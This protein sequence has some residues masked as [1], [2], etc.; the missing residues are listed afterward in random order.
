MGTDRISF[1]AGMELN[2]PPAIQRTLRIMYTSDISGFDLGLTDEDRV[3]LTW[4]KRAWSFLEAIADLWWGA[5]NPDVRSIFVDGDDAPPLVLLN[6]MFPGLRA[7]HPASL[8]REAA[9]FHIDTY[10]VSALSLAAQVA[11]KTDAFGEAAEVAAEIRR[12]QKLRREFLAIR[13]EV[14]PQMQ[15]RPGVHY[16]EERPRVRAVIRDAYVECRPWV[17]RAALTLR[18]YNELVTANLTFILGWAEES[19]EPPV[20]DVASN[21]PI[22]VDVG[23]R[24]FALHLTS[25]DPSSLRH[26]A[27]FIIRDG[28]PLDGPYIDQGGGFQLSGSM[29]IVDRLGLR[30]SDLEAA[31]AAPL[32][33]PS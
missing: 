21:E 6:G 28:G 26:G 15:L 7:K 16:D 22:T 13:Q 5:I 19:V 11:R 18:A 32:G 24:R 30:L 23:R 20:I 8:R 33:S 27:V 4:I 12:Q 14:T 3:Y 17:Q 2:H 10:T 1:L 29:N 9:R 25:H 31:V